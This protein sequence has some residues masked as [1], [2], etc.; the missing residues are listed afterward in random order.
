MTALL[1]GG[2]F[3]E[4]TQSRQLA[5]RRSCTEPVGSTLRK[6]GAKVR[7]GKADELGRTDR[8]AAVSAEEADQPMRSA[9]ISPHRMSRPP[10]VML[11][12]RC[13]LRRQRVGRMVD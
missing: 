5:R 10:T 1:L 3:K 2:I 7:P 6:K 9:G 4:G 12:I 8:P 13:P 11:K